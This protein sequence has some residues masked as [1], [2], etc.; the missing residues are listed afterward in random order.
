MLMTEFSAATIVLNLHIFMN[1]IGHLVLQ[2]SPDLKSPQTLTNGNMDTAP[3]MEP[4]CTTAPHHTRALWPSSRRITP[5]MTF[6]QD[7]DR[8]NRTQ[9]STC[10]TEEV[11]I[12]HASLTSMDPCRYKSDLQLDMCHD[13]CHHEQVGTGGFKNRIISLVSSS[14]L[15]EV[16]P[17]NKM[18]CCCVW[19]QLS[20]HD[21]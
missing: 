9:V 20:G 19:L 13:V 10:N 21:Y 8:T 16:L 17:V 1:Y 4:N 12:T 18:S 6:T 5:M 11:N 2:A 7:R 3:T 15:V 14:S